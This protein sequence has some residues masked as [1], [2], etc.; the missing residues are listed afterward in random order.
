MRRDAGAGADDDGRRL[1][2]AAVI[3]AAWGFAEATIFFIVPD[4]WLTLVSA[5]SLRAGMRACAWTLTGALAGGCVMFAAAARAPDVARAVVVRVPGI[6]PRMVEAVRTQVA[7][8][9][10]VAVLVG[11]AQGRPYKIYASEWGALRGGLAG[12]V[13]ISVPARLVRFVLSILAAA[14]LARLI[15]PWT[16]RRASVERVVL[17]ATWTVFYVLY[18]RAVGW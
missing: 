5:R 13:A 17:L 4:V 16:R 15:A 10:L 6:S 18:F 14:A 2:A 8:R 11:P 1:T 7:D 3:A 9:G 12:F